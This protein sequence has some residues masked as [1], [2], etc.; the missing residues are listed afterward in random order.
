[1]GM[2]ICMHMHIHVHMHWPRSLT[3]GYCRF[4]FM[5]Y[6]HGHMPTHTK[7]MRIGPVTGERVF[8]AS[9]VKN[10]LSVM[11]TCGMYDYSGE[12]AF[13]VVGI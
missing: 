5:M 2:Q 8:G 3:V 13:N 1:M 7:L 11:A 9:T 4:T 12:F 10:A 6:V